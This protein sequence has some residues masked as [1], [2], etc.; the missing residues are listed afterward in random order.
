MDPT[1]IYEDLKEKI[2]WLDLEPG[3]TLNQM[4]IAGSYGVSRNPLAIALTRLE[5]EGWLVRNGSHFVV[6]P[7]TFDRMRETT[8][9]RSVL[10]TQANIW[11][12]NRM[13]PEGLDELKELRDEI[14]ALG[15]ETS[16]KQIVMLDF[17][18]HCILYRE[19][20]NREIYQILERLL[21]HYLR[22]WLAGPQSIDKDLFFTET[23]EIIKALEEK[24][25][26]RLKAATAAHIM[27]SLDKIM[28]IS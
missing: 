4:E 14:L 12:M 1:T 13:S 2:V 21:S 18:F 28:G 20:H 3:S 6:S 9:I 19:T 11:A 24:D 27:V 23:V 8:E 17:K 7:L 10:E 5:S 16:K 26:V 22:F 25:E 15:P